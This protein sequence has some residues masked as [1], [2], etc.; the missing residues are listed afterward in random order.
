MLHADVVGNYDIDSTGFSLGRIPLRW[1]VHQCF[2]ANTGIAFDVKSLV[3]VGIDVN[4]LH[5]VASWGSQQRKGPDSD[6]LSTG[7]KDRLTEE[8]RENKSDVLSPMHDAFH[9][10]LW[11]IL[12]LLPT[13]KFQLKRSPD[14]SRKKVYSC[15][16]FFTGLPSFGMLIRTR[17]QLHY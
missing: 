2:L 17:S 8:Q 15:V 3:D 1:M 10:K 13:R 14:G 7:A 9:D 4:S 11:W 16:S 6:E 12:E 5:S